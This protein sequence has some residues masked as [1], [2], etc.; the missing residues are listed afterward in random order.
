MSGAGPLQLP[1]PRVLSNADV[2]RTDLRLLEVDAAL[3]NEIIENGCVAMAAC[4]CQRV[5]VACMGAGQDPMHAP[6][7]GAVLSCAV[8]LAHI[9]CSSAVLCFAPHAVPCHASVTPL[10]SAPPSLRLHS[11]LSLCVCMCVCVCV[12]ARDS[13][14]VVCALCAVLAHP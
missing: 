8:L 6:L 5:V 13:V 1:G 10:R 3:L 11:V 12:C 2:V 4:F 14:C 7:P 9:H